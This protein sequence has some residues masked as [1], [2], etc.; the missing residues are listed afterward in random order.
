MIHGGVH[1][2]ANV[3]NSALSEPR[4]GGVKQRVSRFGV[5]LALEKAEETSIVVIKVQMSLIQDGRRMR[6]R[7]TVRRARKRLH[8][9]SVYNKRLF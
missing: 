8:F 2:A 3:V 6:P 4:S 5:V 7:D 1:G 9:Y